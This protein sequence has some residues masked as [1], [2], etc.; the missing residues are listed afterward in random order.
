[1][2]RQTNML[3]APGSPR[4]TAGPCNAVIAPGKGDFVGKVAM[5]PFEAKFDSL[6]RKDD[7][8]SKIGILPY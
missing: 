2:A 1:M 8:P 5:R 4:S 3:P 7:F 6:R